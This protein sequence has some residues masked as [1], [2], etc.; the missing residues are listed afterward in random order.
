MLCGNDKVREFQR[1]L[2]ENFER[3]ENIRINEPTLEDIF[4]SLTQ[5]QTSKSGGA[6]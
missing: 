6:L 1:L 2:F 5:K 4:I 3:I